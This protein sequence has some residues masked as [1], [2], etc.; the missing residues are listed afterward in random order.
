MMTDQQILDTI[1]DVN[2]TLDRVCH[3]LIEKA[4]NQ[5]GQDNVTVVMLGVEREP[6]KVL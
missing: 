2:T 5:G 1:L 6:Q 4:N 3:A